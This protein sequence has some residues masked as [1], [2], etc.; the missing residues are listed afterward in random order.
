M[1]RAGK[2]AGDTVYAGQQTTLDHSLECK[3]K[4]R[5]IV[6]CV[7]RRSVIRAWQVASRDY[8]VMQSQAKVGG[9]SHT[10]CVQQMFVG[11]VQVIGSVQA[12][13]V[14]LQHAPVRPAG[15][16]CS[17][18]RSVRELQTNHEVDGAVVSGSPLYLA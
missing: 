4:V 11:C 17:C 6:A 2:R 5:S 8:Q 1:S 12:A 7:G 3:H 13:C 18:G 10:V 14:V 15:Q 16:S 9:L